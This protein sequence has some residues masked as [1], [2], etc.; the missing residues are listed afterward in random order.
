M[1]SKAEFSILTISDDSLL[2]IV[3]RFES[4]STGTVTL[5]L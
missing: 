5:P 1:P 3:A 2:T 4:Q